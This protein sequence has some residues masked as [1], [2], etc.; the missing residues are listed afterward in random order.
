[1]LSV[2]TSDIIYDRL[3][4]LQLY[5]Y[6]TI[7]DFALALVFILKNGINHGKKEDGAE[8]SKPHKPSIVNSL[9]NVMHRSGSDSLEWVGGLKHTRSGLCDSISPSMLSKIPASATDKID[10]LQSFVKERKSL[11]L[12]R[13][14]T[15]FSN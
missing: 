6:P 4:M 11:L 13:R 14:S 3:V 10:A 1:M 12:G 9:K 7:K 5:L 8:S 15:D 2:N